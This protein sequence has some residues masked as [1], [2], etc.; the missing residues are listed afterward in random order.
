MKYILPIF[1][2]KPSELGFKPVEGPEQ[3]QGSSPSVFLQ[4]NMRQLHEA[5]KIKGEWCGE[6]KC[7]LY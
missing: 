2:L 1:S 5:G 4:E 3:D 7:G 6:E